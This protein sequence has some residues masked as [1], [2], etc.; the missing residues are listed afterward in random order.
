MSDLSRRS[1][2]RGAAWS[3]PAV[4]VAGA[5]PALS[6]SIY[7]I[8]CPSVAPLSDTGLKSSSIAS[9]TQSSY[10]KT[11]GHSDIGMGSAFLLNVG[12]WQFSAPDP[13]V[14]GYKLSFPSTSVGITTAS[15]VKSQGTITL[16]QV[17]TPQVIG[18]GLAMQF[19][20]QSG[21]P[22]KLVAKKAYNYP[23]G[24]SVPFCITYLVGLSTTVSPA[25]CFYLNYD[26]PASV[27][28]FGNYPDSATVAN[29]GDSYSVTTTP[30][31]GS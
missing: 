27:D 2:A 6:A 18:A 28:G 11:S 15:G 4:A 13:E 20:I 29:S 9:G 30:K 26:T 22:Y 21:V 23:V 24:F 12:M 19:T 17:T 5:A 14:T 3:I 7:Q 31:Y 8:T 10:D 16:G 1:V 25:C